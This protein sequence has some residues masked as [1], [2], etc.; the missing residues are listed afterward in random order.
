MRDLLVIAHDAN[1]F[2]NAK[3][4]YQKLIDNMYEAGYYRCNESLIP[5]LR[6]S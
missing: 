2:I 6:E 5:E 1:L 3:G 4:Y